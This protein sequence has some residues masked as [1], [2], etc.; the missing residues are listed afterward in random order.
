MRS[1]WTSSSVRGAPPQIDAAS[2]APEAPV[3]FHHALNDPDWTDR[4]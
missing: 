1:D 3:L 4:C 2:L